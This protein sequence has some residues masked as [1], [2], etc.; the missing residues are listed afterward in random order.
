MTQSKQRSLDLSSPLETQFFG[1]RLHLAFQ[2]SDNVIFVSL[3]KQ[4]DVVNRFAVLPR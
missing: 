1:S 3:K 4:P 2:L